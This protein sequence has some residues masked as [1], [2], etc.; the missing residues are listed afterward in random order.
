MVRAS[1]TPG[2]V[3]GAVDSTI[4]P[5]ESDELN[6]IPSADDLPALEGLE[7]LLA[8]DTQRSHA[9]IFRRQRT[10]IDQLRN[11]V[12]MERQKT[13]A[14]QLEVASLERDLAASKLELM[15]SQELAQARGEELAI[16]HAVL[17]TGD[18]YC[19]ADVLKLVQ[20]LNEAIDQC[21][22]LISGVVLQNVTPK[23]CLNITGPQKTA[24]SWL[25]KRWGENLTRRLLADIARG[26]GVLFESI[27]R[28]ML[29]VWCDDFVSSIS[30]DNLEQDEALKMVAGNLAKQRG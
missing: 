10:E 13:N 12:A 20:K 9:I 24:P 21:T 26:D 6:L 11:E 16:A 4:V 27:L 8:E 23:R 1:V 25:T 14:V 7:A 15:L 18:R 5:K 17:S 19:V 3:S 28:N 30:V 29:V 22:G 2:A